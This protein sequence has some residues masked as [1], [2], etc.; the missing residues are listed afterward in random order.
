MKYILILILMLFIS[1][2][3]KD[4]YNN[5]NIVSIET[6]IESNKDFK[7][8]YDKKRNIVCYYWKGYFQ[9]VQTQL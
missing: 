5:K 4:D 2:C 7:I 1:C 3:N 9:C 8:F 6:E